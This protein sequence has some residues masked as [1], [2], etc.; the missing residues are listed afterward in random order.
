MEESKKDYVPLYKCRCCGQVYHDKMIG[1]TTHFN[2]HK[3]LSSFTLGKS[4]ADNKGIPLSMIEIHECGAV[5][6]E[7][8]HHIGISDFIGFKEV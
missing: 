2:I 7:Y 8:E 4:V 1:Q 3:I 5:N 6:R